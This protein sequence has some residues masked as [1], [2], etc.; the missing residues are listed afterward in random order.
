MG[1]ILLLS[2]YTCTSQKINRIRQ[3]STAAEELSA[4][5]RTEE[6][7]ELYLKAASQRQEIDAPDYGFV[8]SMYGQ[9]GI[10]SFQLGNYQNAIRYFQ[11]GL[12]NKSIYRENGDSESSFYNGIA[13]SY[14]KLGSNRRAIEY[15]RR[16][17]QYESNLAERSH[18]RFQIAGNYKA[19]G[20][21]DSMRIEINSILSDSIITKNATQ[22]LM[23]NMIASQWYM[24]LSDSTEAFR[25]AKLGLEIATRIDNDSLMVVTF[26]NMGQ[27]HRNYHHQDSSLIY[28]QMAWEVVSRNENSH[29]IQ[30]IAKALGSIHLS[31][32]QDC[33]NLSLDS[34]AIFHARE[35]TKYFI[36]LD[37]PILL[38]YSYEM[39]LEIDYK[40]HQWITDTLTVNKLAKIIPS[41]GSLDRQLSTF[42]MIHSIYFR[43][44]DYKKSLSISQAQLSIL[45]GMQDTLSLAVVSEYAGQSASKL[46]KY[47]EAKQYYLAALNLHNSL[48]NISAQPQIFLNIANIY[49]SNGY[50]HKAIDLINKASSFAIQFDDSSLASTAFNN[51]GLAYSYLGEYSRSEEIFKRAIEYSPSNANALNNL[52]LVYRSWGRNKLALQYYQ[53]ALDFKL[54]NKSTNIAA[55]LNNIANIYEVENQY[56]QAIEYYERAKVLTQKQNDVESYHTVMLNLSRTYS[57]YGDN[58]KAFI[59]LDEFIQNAKIVDATPSNLVTAFNQYGDILLFD[60]SDEGALE[61]YRNALSVSNES[62]FSEGRFNSL[63]SIAG[64]YY[65]FSGSGSGEVYLDSSE[66]YYELCI[67]EIEN[68]RSTADEKSKREYFSKMIWIY[69]RLINISFVQNDL[70]GVF[71]GIEQS[72]ARVL[73][74]RLSAE[75]QLWETVDLSSVQDLIEHD[76]ALL[77]FAGEGTGTFISLLITSDTLVAYS[78]TNKSLLAKLYPENEDANYNLAIKSLRSFMTNSYP[79]NKYE[80]VCRNLYE[81]FIEPF[82]QCLLNKSKLVIIPD[83]ILNYLPFESL[84]ARDGHYLIENYDISYSQSASIWTFLKGRY[85]QHSENRLLAVGG[86]V[87]DEETY[88]EDIVRNETMLET[89]RRGV[90]DSLKSRGSQRSNYTRLGIL[91]FDNIPGSLT[92]IRNISK[93]FSPSDLISGDIASES[94]IK[95]LSNSGELSKYSQLHF[96]THGIA[97]TD[98][99]EL[100]AIVLSNP[101]IDS[102]EDGFLTMRE[103]SGLNMKAN[104]VILSACETGLGKVYSGEGVVGLTGA[105]TVAGANSVTV[106]LW[107]VNDISTSIFMEGFY[108][109]LGRGEQ[110]IEALSATKRAFINGDYGLEYQNPYYWAPLIHFGN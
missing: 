76:E 5:G 12:D 31:I 100:S 40:M 21:L 108:Q 99:P 28:Y 7:I 91:A 24:R 38:S 75:N 3:I 105:F 60:Y 19:L 57:L 32:S 61:L 45:G 53:K 63:N 104:S 26:Q 107:S 33:F 79:V 90:S 20:L 44:G 46:G 41:I 18:R 74:D 25:T 83:G 72:K 10:L 84:I 30:D 77:M 86:A 89:L 80:S 23:M 4:S 47:D 94:V 56:R 49:L 64:Y 14:E 97:V 109:N 50:P 6:A 66:F 67:N 101:S 34:A 2:L 17:N 1:T 106:S 110:N 78:D 9:A 15:F 48:G 71:E 16:S 69:E 11:E 98:I 102:K 55:E 70:N 29:L 87:Y 96:A 8:E 27:L 88:A 95:A 54:G 52:G 37:D 36:Y 22:Q 82:S 13:L 103:I 62:N 39:L 68:I 93:Y 43:A 92:E 35:S 42:Q 85:Y 59:Y 73:Q 65:F 81:G 51:L 58:D